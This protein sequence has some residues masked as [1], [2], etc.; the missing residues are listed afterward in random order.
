MADPRA[1]GFVRLF[2]AGAFFEAHEVLEELWQEHS[3]DDRPFYQG[4]IQVAVALEHRQR[5]N[6]RGARGV[7]ASARRNLEPFLPAFGGID[8]AAVLHQATR[9][10]EDPG[11]CPPPRLP[12]PGA[13]AAPR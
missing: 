1:R 13:G 7:L 11:R 9:H 3:G 12:E 6:A 4:L 10:I 8:L 5:D 2:N